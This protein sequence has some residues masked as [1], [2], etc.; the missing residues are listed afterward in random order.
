MDIT[1][2][3]KNLIYYLRELEK[4]GRGID[5]FVNIHF[6]PIGN[7]STEYLKV[8]SSSKPIPVQ[9][10]RKPMRALMEDM[11]SGTHMSSTFLLNYEPDFNLMRLFKLTPIVLS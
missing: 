3:E 7:G 8:L 1:P 11:K 4:A 10:I 6:T 5:F 9:R 2:K